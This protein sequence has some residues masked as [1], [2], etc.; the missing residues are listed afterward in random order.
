M[1]L[2]SELHSIHTHTPI[3]K[4]YGVHSLMSE[5]Q[6]GQLWRRDSLQLTHNG[7]RVTCIQG[8]ISLLHQ[9]TPPVYVIIQSQLI[10]VTCD[11]LWFTRFHLNRGV[12]NEVNSER[13]C[14]AL[15]PSFSVACFIWELEVKLFCHPRNI[16]FLQALF[17]KKLS[18]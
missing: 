6:T 15:G 5:R 14:S 2:L 7:L 18:I 10:P 11:N 1:Y 17:L 16:L 4:H 12:F 13:C 9:H 8:R 3:T